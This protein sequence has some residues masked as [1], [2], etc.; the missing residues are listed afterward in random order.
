MW[1]YFSIIVAPAQNDSFSYLEDKYPCLKKKPIYQ[2]HTCSHLCEKSPIPFVSVNLNPFV[3]PECYGWERRL[4]HPK[5]G[6]NI[7]K[8]IYITSCGR[9]LQS[10]KEIQNYLI[11][12]SSKLTIDLFTLDHRVSIYR[13][14][15]PNQVYFEKMDISNGKERVKISCVN[16]LN[17]NS[18]PYVDYCIDRFPGKD[19]NFHENDEFLSGCSC[20][21]NCQNSDTCEC[22]KKTNYPVDSEEVVGYK[23]R[24]LKEAIPSGIYECNSKCKCGPSCG[25]R[26]IQNGIK[27]HLQVF[28]TAMKGWGVRCLHDLE[29][30]TFV[31][32]YVGEVKTEKEAEETGIQKDEYFAELDL[33]ESTERKKE[34][35]ESDAEDPELDIP[36]KKRGKRKN[37]NSEDCSSK[38]KRKN[39]NDSTSDSKTAVAKKSLNIKYA[40]ATSMSTKKNPNNSMRYKLFGENSLYIL[41]AQKKGNVGRYLNHS[42]APNCFVQNAFIDTHDLRFPQVGFFTKEYIPA[43]RELTWDYSYEVGSVKGLM[44]L[45]YCNSKICRG[46]LL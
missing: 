24:R 15:K 43:G 6:Q 34:G 19:V 29:E 27:V 40:S 39:W 7:T 37:Q 11:L 23:F 31:C 2:P 13:T 3:I 42:C 38:K 45:C 20:V 4:L 28:N 22:Q 5:S 14:F 8:V 25:N 26:V 33:I 36:N 10:L 16:T 17:K 1:M 46:R 35:Y 41:D 30:G 9:T 12:V 18:P 21:D 44:K 32:V